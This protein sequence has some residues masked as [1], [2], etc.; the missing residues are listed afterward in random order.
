MSASSSTPRLSHLSQHLRASAILRIGGEVRALMDQG[1]TIHNL[2]VGDFSSEQFPLP[3]EL[4]DGIVDALRDGESTYPPASGI[5]PLRQAIREYYLHRWN[6]DFPIESIL[7]TAGARPPIYGVYRAVVDPGDKVVFGVPCWNNEY[8]V[9]LL[10]AEQVIIDCDASTGF[11]PTA[12][13]L[14]PHVRGARLLALNSPLNPTGTAF[15]AEQL[16]EICDLVLEENKRRGA[17]E[18]PLFVMYDQVYWM[19]TV[20]G[21]EHV[22]PIS[23]RPEMRPYTIL[24]DAIS[25]S[26]AATGL[27]VGWAV[28]PPDIMSAMSDV[29]VHTGAWAPKPE[30]VATAKF[31]VDHAAVDRYMDGLV[32]EVADRLHAMYDGL[33]AMRDD[34]LP[35]DAV[36]PQGGIYV[37]GRFALHGLQ[38]PDGRTL[39]TD[40]DVRSYLLHA[41]GLAIIQFS[42][43]GSPGDRGWFRISIGI[44]TV[45]QINEM[46]PRVRAA[47]EAL[48]GQPAER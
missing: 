41:A 11:L 12:E 17:G 2:T 35:V 8:Y 1:K 14:R 33:I 15:T 22:N 19:I 21:V 7:V 23:V 24:V 10:G 46:L 36:R 44:V 42:A 4:E 18:R 28:A 5:E 38:T 39:N 20:D 3:K 16:G 32:S 26:F 30:Q 45:D 31:L 48:V 6:V 43:F 13:Q 37:S 27:R 29:T 25:K 40:E 9:E 34:G 47:V